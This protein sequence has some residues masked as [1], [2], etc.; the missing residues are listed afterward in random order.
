M[1][2]QSNVLEVL[3]ASPSDVPQHRDVLEDVIKH[4]NSIN[5]RSLG[6]TLLPVRW[7]TDSYPQ[8]GDRPQAL[9]NRQLVQHGD[10]LIGVFWH[11][12]GTPTGK[13]PSGTAEEIDEFR[14]AGKPVA[15]YFCEA[16]VPFDHDPKQLEDLKNYRESLQ[17]D[18]LY[19]T[20]TTAEQL[21]Q[22]ASTHLPKI[23]HE[24]T[25]A[26]AKSND[27]NKE[28]LSQ[29]RSLD[30]HWVS[31][32]RN[33]VLAAGTKVNHTGFVEI[34]SM[35]AMRELKAKHGF[36]VRAV[37]T[38]N[39]HHFGWPFAVVLNNNSRCTSQTNN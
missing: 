13:A 11:K 10:I 37:Q 6:I 22:L 27:S 26:S 17:S 2:R 23:V 29:S 9:L 38:S 14:K 5:S 8:A 4:W 15:L 12:L 39:L 34:V 16:P 1:P 35:L 24:V 18:F 21:W 19:S 20:F 33:R 32:H 7:E 25:K 3:I 31:F 36:L 30:S 28:G